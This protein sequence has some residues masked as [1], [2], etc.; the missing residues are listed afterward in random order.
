MVLEFFNIK[1]FYPI[2][3]E[4]NFVVTLATLLCFLADWAN[5]IMLS[6]K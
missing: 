3:F 1:E 2:K 4:E 6:S 5:Y